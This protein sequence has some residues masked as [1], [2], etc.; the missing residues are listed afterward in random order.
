MTY[1]VTRRVQRVP[2]HVKRHSHSQRGLQ[3]DPTNNGAQNVEELA[4]DSQT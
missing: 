4:R 3:T 1:V 2:Y